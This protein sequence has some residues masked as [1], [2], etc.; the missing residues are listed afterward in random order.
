MSSEERYRFIR[1]EMVRRGITNKQISDEAN[2]S[3]EYLFMVLKGARKGYRVRLMVAQK[4]QLPVEYL[5]PDT[6]L[7]YR[8]AA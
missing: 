3:R 1:S 8:E 5:F 7:E 4:C 2:C 6:P